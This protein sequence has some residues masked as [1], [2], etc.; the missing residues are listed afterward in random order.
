MR[1]WDNDKRGRL[2]IEG[3]IAPAHGKVILD[4]LTAGS[5]NE[6]GTKAHRFNNSVSKQAS[7]RE[8]QQNKSLLKQDVLLFALIALPGVRDLGTCTPEGGKT[9]SHLVKLHI[10]YTDLQTN[11]WH[12]INRTHLPCEWHPNGEV[13]LSEPLDI[14][15]KIHNKIEIRDVDDFNKRDTARFYRQSPFE[16]RI[17]AIPRI[18][19][20]ETWHRLDEITEEGP[21]TQSAHCLCTQKAS[22]VHKLAH[23]VRAYKFCLKRNRN[24]DTNQSPKLQRTTNENQA[25]T[26][27]KE[28]I[29]EANRF[30]KFLSDSIITSITEDNTDL[31]EIFNPRTPNKQTDPE[32]SITEPASTGINH[33][34]K[35]WIPIASPS[36]GEL[37]PSEEEFFTM[38]LGPEDLITGPSGS[39]REAARRD[40]TGTPR[41]A[42]SSIVPNTREYP[43]LGT[44]T[45]TAE[46]CSSSQSSSIYFSDTQ[47]I[48]STNCS[49][50]QEQ[51]RI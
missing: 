3:R 11:S 43:E 17:T 38:Q 39:E 28:L 22:F 10:G 12:K 36:Y 4:Y 21:T 13:E 50:T 27:E 15:L 7:L 40:H 47:S 49:Y 5:T 37:T 6:G 8:I 30:A 18:K 25:N 24:E 34:A 51:N 45:N 19:I 31:Q 48:T 41:E 32:Q 44:T 29:D 23:P 20:E 33:P 26:K 1:I 2:L 16:T 46:S 9:G 42:K 35:F 14:H